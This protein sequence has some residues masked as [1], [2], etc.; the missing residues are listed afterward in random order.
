VKP[1]KVSPSLM[2]ADFLR[3]CEELDVMK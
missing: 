1:V 3:L 2:C